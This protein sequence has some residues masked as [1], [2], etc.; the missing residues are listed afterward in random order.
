MAVEGVTNDTPKLPIPNFSDGYNITLQSTSLDVPVVV[1]DVEVMGAVVVDDDVG[2]EIDDV[3]VLVVVVVVVVIFVVVASVLPIG[4]TLLG[5]LSV[6]E[7][8]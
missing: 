8:S 6:Y 4:I 1:V 3:V 7:P 2:E 5:G